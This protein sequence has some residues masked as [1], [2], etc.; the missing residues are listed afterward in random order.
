MGNYLSVFAWHSLCFQPTLQTPSRTKAILT[1]RPW[2]LKFPEQR[3]AV[4]LNCLATCCVWSMRLS[5]NAAG[6]YPWKPPVPSARGQKKWRGL[7]RQIGGSY[8]VKLFRAWCLVSDSVFLALPFSAHVQGKNTL[9]MRGSAIE[10]VK[11]IRGFLITP[12]SN[13]QACQHSLKQTHVTLSTFKG[14]WSFP[15]VS[16]SSYCGPNPYL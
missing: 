5:R 3:S 4:Q 6:V 13:F 12:T 14:T 15:N 7:L 10:C 9:R 16:H 1:L 11:V 8:H 2:S